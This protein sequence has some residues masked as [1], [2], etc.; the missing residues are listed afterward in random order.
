MS[1]VESV[2]GAT[3][4]ASGSWL[5]SVVRERT[6]SASPTAGR[7]LVGMAASH[8]S[9]ASSYVRSCSG[10]VPVSPGATSASRTRLAN[11]SA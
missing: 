1:W 3:G 8:L 11:D 5:S 6:A 2:T 10:T 9:F 7:I 4:S